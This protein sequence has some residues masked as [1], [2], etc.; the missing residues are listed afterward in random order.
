MFGVRGFKQCLCGNC[1]ASIF[2]ERLLR[3]QKRFTKLN[4]KFKYL[5][6]TYLDPI[7]TDD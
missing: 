6:K 4:K 5:D 2:Q 1:A 7:H 3:L